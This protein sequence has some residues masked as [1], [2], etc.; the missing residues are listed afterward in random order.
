MLENNGRVQPTRAPETAPE[1][2][3]VKRE[4]PRPPRSARDLLDE[5]GRRISRNRLPIRP[6]LLDPSRSQVSRGEAV[7][8]RRLL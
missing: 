5:C 6:P 1:T 7:I 4:A 3:V 8:E 2:S